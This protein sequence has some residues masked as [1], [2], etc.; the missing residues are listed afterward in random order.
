MINIGKERQM[1]WDDYIIDN[2]LTTAK[3]RSGKP[4]FQRTIMR[5]GDNKS[6]SYPIIVNDDKGY[7]MYYVNYIPGSSLEN[8]L[9]VNFRVIES[10]DGINWKIPSLGLFEENGSSDNNIVYDD[11]IDNFFVMYDTN[12]KCDPS[13][14]YKAVGI[15][16]VPE[17][18][19]RRRGL[20]YYSSPDGYHFTKRYVITYEGMFD[21]NNVLLWDG[22]EYKLYIRNYHNIPAEGYEDGVTD[23]MDFPSWAILNEGIRDIRI[24]TSKDFKIWSK[25]ERIAFDDMLDYPLY[26]NQVMKCDRASNLFIGF[27]TRYN[28]KKEWENIDEMPSGE[29]KRESSRING[30]RAGLTVTDCIFMLSRDGKKWHRYNESFMSPGYEG[31]D[32]WIYGDAYP[33]YGF[34]D[35]GDE[36]MYIYTIDYHLSPDVEKPLNLWA[37]RKDGFAYYEADASGAVITTKPIVFEGRYMHLNF[38][39]SAYGNIFVDVLDE[40]GNALNTSY[41]IY[42]NNIDR[43]VYFKDGTDFSV[44]SGKNVKLRFR[45]VDAKIYSMKFE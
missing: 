21:T 34:I 6:I 37:I 11:F 8:E 16:Y 2:A 41:E 32:N 29:L 38:E 7:K 20:W 35:S 40:D 28:E 25:P 22:T 9:N 18:G 44:Y 45:M 12:P 14:K 33:A 23:V 30:A 31:K 43:K 36:N 5:I 19:V 4:Q 3:A 39:T 24:M 42:G 13:E 27:P 26:T 1:F 15:N 10:E 17:N